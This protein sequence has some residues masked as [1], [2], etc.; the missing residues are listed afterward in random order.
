MTNNTTSPARLPLRLEHEFIFDADGR[1]VCD[2]AVPDGSAMTDQEAADH[3]A[4]I[5]RACNAN[6]ELLKAC[7]IALSEYFEPEGNGKIPKLLRA[8]IAEAEG[9]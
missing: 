4:F 6:E 3:A 7:K 8:A 1:R 5:V 2:T 9:R